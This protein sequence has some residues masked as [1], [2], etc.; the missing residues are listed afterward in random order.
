MSDV[1]FKQVGRNLTLTLPDQ[2]SITLMVADKDE[3][4]NI[5]SEISKLAGDYEKTK[6]AKKQKTLSNKMKKLLTAKEK[7]KGNIKGKDR[8]AKISQ[9]KAVATGKS[10]KKPAKTVSN[11]GRQYRGE[12]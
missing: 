6:S 5:K 4:D 9:K 1:K 11:S 2:P 7:A 8:V 12:Y 3:R 10:T